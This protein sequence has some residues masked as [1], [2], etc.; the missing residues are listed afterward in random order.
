MKT[1]LLDLDNKYKS[2]D[3]EAFETGDSPKVY[4]LLN[5]SYSDEAIDL[6]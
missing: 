4:I 3:S 1:F 2:L 5:P 6:S